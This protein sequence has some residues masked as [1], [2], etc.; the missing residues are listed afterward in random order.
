MKLVVCYPGGDYM[1]PIEEI[2]DLFDKGIFSE[3]Y[4]STKHI[5]LNSDC[6]MRLRDFDLV[7]RIM[8]RNRKIDLLLKQVGVY[9]PISSFSLHSWTRSS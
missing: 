4:V 2:L 6:C 1:T 9:T 8:D 3:G 7:K 5:W